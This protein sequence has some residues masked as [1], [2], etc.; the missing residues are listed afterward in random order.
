MLI[1]IPFAANPRKGGVAVSFSVG[2]LI[3]LVY[4]VLFKV[5]QTAGY[6]ERVPDYVAVWGVNAL[7][8]LLGVG[9]LL[10]ARK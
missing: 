6:N 2:A 8:F 4:F 3:A 9:A 10:K 1:S 5:L 7:F